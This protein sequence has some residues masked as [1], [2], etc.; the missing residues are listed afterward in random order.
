[1]LQGW[2]G[3][4]WKKRSLIELTS[5]NVSEARADLQTAL[6]LAEQESAKPLKT[7]IEEVLRH[8]E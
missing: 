3:G 1:M 7:D 6:K 5:G 8:L 2:Q 4:L